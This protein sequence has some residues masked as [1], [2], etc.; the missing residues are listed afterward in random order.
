MGARRRR[1]SDSRCCDATRAPMTWVDFVDPVH[2]SV[3]DLD[4]WLHGLSPFA[5]VHEEGEIEALMEA[6]AAGQLWD[7][8]DAT[9]H[10]KPIRENPEVFELRRSALS[11]KLRFYHGEPAELPRGLVAL[12]RHIKTNDAAQQAEIEYAAGRY[13]D[14]RTTLWSQ[15]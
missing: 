4:Q 2:P 6:A 10:I 7:S 13:Q 14:G 5:R 3:N 9:T 11:K 15:S 8:G 12:H 1:G